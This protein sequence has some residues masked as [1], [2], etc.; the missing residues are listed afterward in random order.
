MGIFEDIVYDEPLNTIS[1]LET[2]STQA[3]VRIDE[4]TLKIV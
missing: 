4:H 1:K 3:V 2:K